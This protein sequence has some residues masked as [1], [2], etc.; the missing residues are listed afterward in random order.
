MT[1]ARALK[2]AN[3]ALVTGDFVCPGK[4]TTVEV[5]A[6]EIATVNTDSQEISEVISPEQMTQLPSLN[7]K[8]RMTL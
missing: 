4:V 8:R 5:V 6:G 2:A 1:S 7:R 3:P